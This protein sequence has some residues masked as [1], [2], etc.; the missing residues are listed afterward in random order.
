MKKGLLTTILMAA[1]AGLTALLIREEKANAGNR[2]KRRAIK[3]RTEEES[4]ELVKTIQEIESLPFETKEQEVKK[5]MQPLIDEDVQEIQVDDFEEEDFSSFI[6]SIKEKEESYAPSGF[7]EVS[8][9]DF[10]SMFTPREQVKE[11]PLPEVTSDI[12]VDNNRPIMNKPDFE[13]MFVSDDDVEEITMSEID[14]FTVDDIMGF[15]DE[16]QSIIT[17][18]E[19]SQVF[20]TE[21]VQLEDI[22]LE[23]V[24]LVE[25]EDQNLEEEVFG[26]KEE[27]A[28]SQTVKEIG[29][30]YPHLS[31]RFIEKV[32][33]QLPQYNEEFGSGEDCRIIH[34]IQFDEAKNLMRFIEVVRSVGYE[35]VGTDEDG[36]ILIQLDF[37]NQDSKILSEI[38]NV[39]NQSSL[40]NGRYKGNE[41]E[42]L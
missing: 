28:V 34:K 25:A 9:P 1:G 23:E 2:E 26:K 16:S 4:Q 5:T 11:I 7:E 40:L 15:E 27:E 32:L 6:N 3:M 24:K 18:P 38:Y 13:K 41:L 19:M 17:K 30:L 35:V 12:Q 36:H 22:Q 20:D 39:A 42:K 31:I 33:S 37:K 29:L 10:G 14:E 21:D 8:E